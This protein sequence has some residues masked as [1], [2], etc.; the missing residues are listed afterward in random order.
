MKVAPFLCL[1]GIAW[2]ALRKWECVRSLRE[3]IVLPIAVIPGFLE[4]TAVSGGNQGIKAS[5][6]ASPVQFRSLRCYARLSGPLDEGAT[7]TLG[8]MVLRLGKTYFM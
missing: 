5:A 6:Y 3:R 8:G 4:F 1:W 2:R 7:F